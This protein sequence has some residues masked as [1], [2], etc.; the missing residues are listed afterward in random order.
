M[1]PGFAALKEQY[2]DRF[3]EVFAG[4]GIAALVYDNRCFG[5]SGGEPRQEVDPV[6]Q[7]RDYRHAVTYASSLPGID[8]ARIGAWGSSYSG[9]HAL[10]LGAID[11]RVRCVVAQVPTI[12]G[13]EVGRRRTRPDLEAPAR[14]R[15]DA[16]RVARYHGEPPALVP[17]V[18]DDP[19]EPCAIAGPEAFAHFQRT[20]ALAP[21]RRNEVTLRSLELAR[22]YEPGTWI[23]RVAPTPL[24]MIVAT[25]DVTTPADLQLAAYERAREP[26]RLVLL[27]AGHFA[28]YVEEFDAAAGAARDWLVEHLRP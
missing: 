16:D 2:L 27:D 28:P 18:A 8:P 9:G 11:R 21:H 15:F 5:S 22:E 26:K 13:F 20:L 4:A 19:R 12:S 17:L 1:S 25:R 7:L 24:L 23:E 6:L 10:V 14:A 3:A